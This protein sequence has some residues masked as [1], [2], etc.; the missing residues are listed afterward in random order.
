MHYKIASFDFDHTLTVGV[1]AAEHLACYLGVEQEIGEAETAFHRGEMSTTAFTNATAK[2][3]AGQDV[4]EIQ[5][6]IFTIPLV[7]GIKELVS[8]LKQCGL[9]VVVN[10]VGYRNILVPLVDHLGFD[11]VS[12]VLLEQDDSLFTGNVVSYFP[13]EKKI[14]FAEDQANLVGGDLSSVIAVGDGISDIPLFSVVGG[15]I[16]FNANPKINMLATLATSG[17][18]CD[19]LHRAFEKLLYPRFQI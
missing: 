18:S 1:A 3:L 9:R 15:S 8:Q 13:L 19:S 17:E 7:S 12:G 11:D 5:S 14:K 6:Y 2:F 4:T 10:T 16:A